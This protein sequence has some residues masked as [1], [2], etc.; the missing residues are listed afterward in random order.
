MRYSEQTFQDWTKP[1]S[2]TEEKRAENTINMIR[3]AIEANS[4]LKQLDYEVFT[5]GS[6]A[7]NTNVRSDSDVDVCVMLRS[8]FYYDLPDNKTASDYGF[9]PATITFQRYRDLVKKALQDKFGLQY[10]TDGNKS[11]KVNENTYHVQ[12]D[13]VPAFQY[14]NYRVPRGSSSFTEGTRFYAK[15]GTE[16]TNYPKI[17]IANG[18]GKN[19]ATNKQYKALV[20]IMKHI[21]NEMVDDNETDGDIITSFLVECL[22]WNT[23]NNIITGYSTWTKTIQ[24]TIGYLYNSI[25]NGQHKEWGEVSEMLYLFH[26]G[27][28]WKDSEVKQW[29]YDAWN[30]IGY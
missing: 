17:H 24:E 12:A 10:V 15:D 21:K 28:K 20:R 8:T 26:L 30:Y 23:P 6:F 14:R 9:M 3:S 11:L 5:Q 2:T 1:L 22:V 18:K 19:V 27:R 4:E 13:V 7:N 16:V 29:L 25:K